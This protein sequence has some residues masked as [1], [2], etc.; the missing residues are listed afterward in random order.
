GAAR[1][2]VQRGATGAEGEPRRA[3]REDLERN[4]PN[5]P[6]ERGKI[7]LYTPKSLEYLTS[8]TQRQSDASESPWLFLI[9]LLVLVAEQALAVHLSFHLKGSEAQLPAAPTTPPA[10]PTAACPENNAQ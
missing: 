3:T 5:P 4:P 7:N 9:M 10:P 1:A 8:L 6:R 2:N